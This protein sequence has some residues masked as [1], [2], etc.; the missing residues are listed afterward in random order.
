MKP[1]KLVMSAFGPYS[2]LETI[3]FSLFENS[4][5]LISGPTGAGKTTIFD[6]ITYA[7][8]GAA[9]GDTRGNG[10]F[11]SDF[12]DPDTLTFV[13]FIFSYEGVIYHI[14]RS[15]DQL[16]P[17]KQKNR[18][19]VKKPSTVELSSDSFKLP[20]SGNQ[21]KAKL[22]DILH[23]DQDQFESTMMIAQGEFSK[24]INAKTSDRVAI[25]RQIL[26]TQ[27]LQSFATTLDAE[28][29]GSKEAVGRLNSSLSAIIKDFDFSD[30]AL[31]KEIASDGAADKLDIS[32]LDLIKSAMQQDEI[33][34]KELGKGA[35]ESE[36]AKD[37]ANAKLIASEND[38]VHLRNYLAAK[39][40]L[41][42]LSGA[43]DEFA[44]KENQL[45]RAEE[46]A[47][48]AV[49]L[50]ESKTK[51]TEIRKS[52]A[53]LAKKQ[54]DEIAAKKRL[55]EAETL[56][57]K[58]PELRK[59][60][61][62]LLSALT[63]KKALL[64]TCK[65]RDE[66]LG[67]KETCEKT[68]KEKKEAL[69][70]A[71]TS[72]ADKTILLQTIN[73][74][75]SASTLVADKAAFQA[76]L[77]KFALDKSLLSDVNI[78]KGKYDEKVKTAS[79]SATNFKISEEN[80]KK[81]NEE[82][83]ASLSAYLANQAGVLASGLVAGG[84]CPVCGSKEHPHPALASGSALTDAA[85][86][87]LKDSSDRLLA[88]YQNDSKKAGEDGVQVKSG[89]EALKESYEKVDSLPPFSLDEITTVLERR[90][91][92]LL[93][94]S[95]DLERKKRALEDKEAEEKKLKNDAIA[96]QK[97]IAKLTA[98][99]PEL[100]KES[101]ESHDA[102]LGLESELR[103]CQAKAGSFAVKSLNEEIAKDGIAAAELERKASDYVS[104]Q[105][106]E[107]GVH[108]SL[109]SAVRELSKNLETQKGS[110]S[111]S[112]INLA[113]KIKRSSFA[114]EEEMLAALMNPSEKA[115]LKESVDA[116]KKNLQQNLGIVAEFTKLGYDK[117][118]AVDLAPLK[119]IYETRK[120]EALAAHTLH[121]TLKEK[122]QSNARTFN[123]LMK[124]LAASQAERSK[125]ERALTLSNVA[126][127]KLITGV[128]EHLS[129]EVY[130]QSLFFEEILGRASDKFSEMSDGRYTMLRHIGTQGGGAS[131]LDIDVLDT[132][133]GKV[134]PASSLSGGETFMASLSLALSLS[135]NI[136]MRSG[137][138]QLESMFIDEGF[139]TLD[140]ESL[141][142][143]IGILKKISADGNRMI[144]IIS[145]VETLSEVIAKQIDVIK[146]KNGSR[147]KIS[148]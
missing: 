82:Y 81:K 31:M 9:S 128:N 60:K 58:A 26:K 105:A 86:K 6:A 134:R 85:L 4:L 143:A 114:S 28:A 129:F 24:L 57:A 12:A 118:V 79:F 127:G 13:D 108:S 66:L 45:A 84:A 54:I 138:I 72:L 32:L 132:N 35:E 49:Y 121:D 124:T 40:K 64:E 73:D 27:D 147:I 18:G 44:L 125:A 55:G 89:L 17:S 34:V 56:A 53:F 92:E 101:D 50:S 70:K 23:L 63:E 39:E 109:E 77:I 7:L 37:E 75:L 52:E 41:E 33:R 144:G 8:Y 14:Y 137:G 115:S 61:D 71:K 87:I 140:P 20:F 74:G 133:T 142:K 80:Y 46:A 5:F 68:S 42:T 98:S 107:L 51:E 3:D 122:G 38:N 69:D 78:K 62:A 145:H 102:A 94:A 96:F 104:R 100:Q 120:S 22:H 15:P 19:L 93:K 83:Q 131:G 95:H 1:L 126:N 30:S 116:F 110:L 123:N 2:G 106:E 135:E 47:P 117:L 112:R 146:E 113:E 148:Y 99:L 119:D 36:K 111:E 91:S 76:E 130:Y 43:K 59:E 16:V 90:K 29:K 65:K 21:V 11:R 139:G 136:Q 25:F 67:K 88:V 141:D 103:A 10:N 48:L 97:D